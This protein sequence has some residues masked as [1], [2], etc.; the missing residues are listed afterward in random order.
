MQTLLESV[1]KEIE[2][3]DG[4]DVSEITNTSSGL[5]VV[6]SAPVGIDRYAEVHFSFARAF[7]VMDEGDMLEYW[8]APLKSKHFLYRVVSGGWRDRAAGHYLHV[9]SALDQ[10]QEWLIVSECLCVS[11]IS[12]QPPHVREYS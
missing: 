3:Y 9:T 10:M 7:Q 11:V 12:A 6:L 4:S 5:R 2:W 8:H 1:G